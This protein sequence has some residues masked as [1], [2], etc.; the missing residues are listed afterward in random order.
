MKAL[1][2]MDWKSEPELVEVPKPSPG[3][4]QVVV[5]IG[6]AGACHSDL[7]V[8]HDF[9]PGM[10]PWKMPFT[11]GHENAGWVDSVGDGVSTVAEGDSVAIY[12]PW[13]CGKCE[14]CRLGIENYCE[15]QAAAP[16]V[17]GGAG[18]GLDGGMAEYLLVPFERLLVPLPENV[19][20]A[21]AA[22]LTDAGLT[23][24]HA[25][26]RSWSKMTPTST[27]VVIGVGGLG[28]VALQLVKATTAARVIAVD[29]RKEA[30]D[31]AT[32]MGADDVVPS[33]DHAAAAIK[34]LTGG[35]G[36][37]VLL[38]FVGANPTIELA[39][40]AARPLGD[41]TIV[42]IGGGSVPLSFFS[43]PYEV[44][45]QTTYWG[46]HPELVELLDLASRALVHVESTTYSL[47]EAPQ[48]YRD[49]GEGKVRGR[50]VVVPQ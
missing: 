25:I 16:A 9:E 40:A 42:G 5:K 8:M 48:A 39:R 7:H 36:A 14:R 1:R 33:D 41:V 50:A 18:L 47:D 28:H 19:E 31:L 38:D 29:N 46:A 17:N 11:L 35:R 37:D 21:T 34:D 26:R 49:L 23:P 24:Y 6:G 4:G 45:I 30:L 12:G 2:L 10:M 20:P 3:P 32:T 44:S 15:N 27:V 13:G 43:Q 22:P